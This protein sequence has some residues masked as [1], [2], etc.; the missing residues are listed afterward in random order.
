MTRQTAANPASSALVWNECQT[1]VV[2]CAALPGH[3]AIH[4]KTHTLAEEIIIT[5]ERGMWRSCMLQVSTSVG[6]HDTARLDILTENQL[7]I[8]Y[9]ISSAFSR[10]NQVS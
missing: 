3:G 5:L 9:N 6:M 7:H 1:R 2:C 10:L 4:G 8:I